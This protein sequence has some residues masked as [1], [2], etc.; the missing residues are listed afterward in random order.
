MK[1]SHVIAWLCFWNADLLASIP[2]HKWQEQGF[3]EKEIR[4][5]THGTKI[6]DR[7]SPALKDLT[8]L[9]RENVHF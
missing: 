8:S 4:F 7:E 6:E 2:I 9:L 1:Y 3:E 5:I